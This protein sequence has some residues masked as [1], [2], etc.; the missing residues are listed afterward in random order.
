M[1]SML[2]YATTPLRRAGLAFSLLGTAC[3][4][5]GSDLGFGPDEARVV[6]VVVYLDRDGSHTPTQGLDTLYRGARVA[7]FARGSVDTF[8]VATTNTFGTALFS[9]VPLGQYRV[10]VVPS[11][12]GDSIE[13]QA[14]TVGLVDTKVLDRKELQRLADKIAKAKATQGRGGRGS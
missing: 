10:A 11:S 8:K 2:Q 9:Q 13:V 6:A 1:R 3:V 7:L 5:S 14:I 4:N 12:I